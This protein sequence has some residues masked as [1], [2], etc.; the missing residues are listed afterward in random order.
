MEEFKISVPVFSSACI[1]VILERRI[2]SIFVTR[3]GEVQLPHWNNW[4][5]CWPTTHTQAEKAANPGLYVVILPR[6]YISVIDA[7]TVHVVPDTSIWGGS[8]PQRAVP[9]SLFRRP[10]EQPE[11]H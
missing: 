3:R 6:A 11:N 2:L 10:W 5:D 7:D 9:A 8:D 4:L 1:V